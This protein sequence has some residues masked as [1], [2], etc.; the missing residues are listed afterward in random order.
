ANTL[1]KALIE[2]NRPK[3][4]QAILDAAMS[5]DPENCWSHMNQGWIYLTQNKTGE[6]LQHFHEAARINP[7]NTE[8]HGYIKY[9]R[10]KRLEQATRLVLLAILVILFLIKCLVTL[11]QDRF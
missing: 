10:G 1:A 2:T 8:A 11:I 6:S 3:Q 9:L 5:R 4:A 7:E